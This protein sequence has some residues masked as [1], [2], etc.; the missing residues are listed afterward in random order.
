MSTASG[1][2][3][4]SPIINPSALEPLFEPW[5]EPIA[6]RVRSDKPEARSETRKGRRP[7]NLVIAQNLRS[8]VKEWRETFYA[9]A[10]DTTRQLFSYWFDRPHRM[11]TQDGDEFEFRYYF[12]QR[13][14][15]ETFVYLKELRQIEC[16]S[17]L[18]YEFGGPEAKL[19]ALGIHEEEDAW[20]RYA[21]KLA[22]GAGKTKVMSL[23]IV[24]SYFH[25]LRESESLMARHFVVIAP[26]LTVYERLKEDFGDEKIFDADPLIPPEWRG[27]WNMSVI[28]Q[29]EAGGATTGGTIYLTNIHRLY[30]PAKRKNSKNAETYEWMGPPVSKTKALDTGES[31]RQRVTSH[32]R[33]MVL[34][35][36]AHHIWD[37]DSAWNEALRYLHDT[38]MA[39]SGGQIV[40][41][42]D[43]SATPKDNKAQYFKHIIC[44]TPLGEAV[45][46]G[47]VKTPIIGRADKKLSEEASDN[48][49]YRFDRHIRLGYARWLKSKSEWEKSGKKALLFVMCEDTEAADQIARRLNTDETFKELNGKTIN[50]HTN[51]KGKLKKI[52]KGANA[53]YEFVENE[54]EISDE[55]LK[56]L[57]KLSRDL[58]KNSSP[59]RCIVS[60]LMLREGWDVRNVTTIVPLR[61]YSSKADI[62]PEQTLGRG[63]R[64]MT[65][66]GSQGA[67]ELVTVVDHPAFAS[68]YQHELAQE[69]LPLEIVDVDSIPATTV[70]IFP[71][72]S[73][74][75]FD[76]L[77]IAVPNLTPGHRILPKLEGLGID[78]VKNEFK[79]YKPLPLGKKGTEEIEYEGRHLFTGEVIEKMKI[80]LPLLESGVGAISY[81]VKQLE[82]ICK[83]SG[84]HTSLAPLLQEFLEE[85]L[86]D[87]KTNLFDPALAS[88]LAD[89]DVAEHIRAI[90]VP[91]IRKRTTTIEQRL[92]GAEPMRLSQWKP[93]QVTH[94]ERRP[95]L[96]ADRTLFNLAP[97]NR[98]LEVAVTKFLDTASDVAAFA[99]NAGP[100]CLRIDYLTAN[101]RLAFYTPDFF[102]RTQNGNYYL[103]ET[104]GREDVDV[105]RKARAAVAWCESAST[106]NCKWEYVYVPQGVFGRMTGNSFEALVRT[107]RPALENVLQSEE[108]E[109]RFPLFAG[110]LE[111]EEERPELKDLVDEATLKALP[112][113][114]QKAVEQAA[115]LFRFL[116][117]KQGINFA[118]VFNPLLGSL[119]E[120]AKGLILRKLQ[121]DLPA[122]VAEQKAWFS[123]YLEDIDQPLRNRL[124]KMA[125][126]LKRT[127]V[128]NNGLSPVGLLRSCL[129]YAIKEK[130][131][132]GGVFA[133]VKSHF[134]FAN[135]AALL[136]QVAD[137]NDFRN[138]YVAH[139]G[140]ELTDSQLAKTH[141]GKW[142]SG[143]RSIV[144]TG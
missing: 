140:K 53:R 106:K 143:L 134:A 16:L 136:D 31:L 61:P 135:A 98:E 131:Q 34:N 12:C 139:Q 60:V 59:Y 87:K 11:K 4:E 141:L 64:R 39:R 81:Y 116:E 119:D 89:S 138:T 5:E 68:L 47:I 80:Y 49:A 18:V 133:A 130:A 3:I 71:D 65:P 137:I 78:D 9:G 82:S 50:L 63:L 58:D 30:D 66:P 127:L 97:C 40:A 8:K 57:R 79:K 102:A 26:N 35:D 13:E 25:S 19:A 37:P 7:S 28:L 123:P 46:A 111:P 104:K 44:D 115:M 108:L 110:V 51:L 62:L 109:E 67:H 100:Q 45:D 77:E 10:S 117:N 114:Y 76:D 73:R 70:T 23:A 69:G 93:F 99:K 24:W 17:Q 15:I 105:P 101:G 21:F 113:R 129:E 94:S 20:S 14:A 54:K 90:F 41:Q 112:S 72:E 126:N 38:M 86:F 96:E 52:G 43:F 29:D 42:L 121:N 122:T 33:I 120:A 32:K 6:H 27:D 22:T 107:C 85:I 74:K 124:E 55:D 142:S 91:L 103:V 75:R 1:T 128:F 95:V 144:E 132:I 56:A 48:A 84:L 125:G 36:E 83:L 92:P 2:S 88:R 118:S